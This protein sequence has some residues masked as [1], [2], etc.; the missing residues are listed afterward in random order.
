[1]LDWAVD[2]QTWQNLQAHPVVD[3]GS[4][5]ESENERSR[6]DEE[7]KANDIS[8]EDAD[9]R[10]FMQRMEHLEDEDNELEDDEA[11]ASRDGTED[12]KEPSQAT[13]DTPKEKK[14]ALSDSSSNESTVFVRNLPY[15]VTDEVL[16][17]HFNQIGKVRYARTVQS[18][19]GRPAGTAFVVS[20]FTS[21]S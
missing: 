13:S 1:M 3:G 17:E 4:D 21:V 11:E 7:E 12:D 18:P 16:K 6:T 5:R 8:E 15:A 20:T 2:K 14:P 9:L 19:D 10:S